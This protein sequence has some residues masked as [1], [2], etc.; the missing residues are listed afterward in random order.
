M[1]LALKTPAECC[2]MMIQKHADPKA[3]DRLPLV[4][5]AWVEAASLL[6]ERESALLSLDET[7]KLHAHP[8]LV[9]QVT[10]LNPPTTLPPH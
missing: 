7:I 10:A 2:D 1:W 9:S 8:Q 6:I 3:A 5:N 4:L